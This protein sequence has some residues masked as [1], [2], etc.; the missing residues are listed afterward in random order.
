[1]AKKGNQNDKYEE[2]HIEEDNFEGEGEEVEIEVT[3]ISLSED[4]INYWIS[5]LEGLREAHGGSI[6]LE[7]DD[8]SELLIN[9]DENNGRE[10]EYAEEEKIVEVF[11]EDEENE[12]DEDTEG[13][14]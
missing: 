4:E 1:M 13:E 9:Y 7:L 6:E 12:V 14:N 8:E 10:E 5:K 11:E 2:V 3:E